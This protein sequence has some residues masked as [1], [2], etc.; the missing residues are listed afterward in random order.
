MLLL[1]HNI[2]KKEQIKKIVRLEESDWKEYKVKA[3]CNNTV[4]NNKLDS[5]YLFSLYYLVLWKSYPEK[6][7]IWEPALVKLDFCKM[8]ITFYNNYP[9]KL[10]KIFSPIDSALLIVRPITKLILR[11]ETITKQKPG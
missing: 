1:K 4:Y 2:I 11:I 8:I 3:I 7:N 10:T 5:G 9:M 6:E